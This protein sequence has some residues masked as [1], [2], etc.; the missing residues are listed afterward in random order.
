MHLNGTAHQTAVRWCWVREIGQEGRPHY[1]FVLMLNWDAYPMQRFD[2]AGENTYNR[3]QE[4][5]AGELRISVD[6]A[7]GLAYTAANAG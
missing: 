2:S 7:N 5:W 4:A 6:D 1:H 3:L